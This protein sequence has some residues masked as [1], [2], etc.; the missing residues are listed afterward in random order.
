MSL[1]RLLILLSLLSPSIWRATTDDGRGIDPNGRP[2]ITSSLSCDDGA[3]L[4][5]HGGCA[6]NNGLDAGVRIDPEG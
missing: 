1:I 6:T 3:G 2:A 4:D 5:P